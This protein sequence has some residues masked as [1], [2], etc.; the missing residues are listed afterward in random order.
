MKTINEPWAEVD[1]TVES[2]SQY[3][4]S[5]IHKYMVGTCGKL[6]HHPNYIAYHL[7]CEKTTKHCD[8]NGDPEP[9]LANRSKEEGRRKK[10]PPE[11]WNGK[12]RN[13]ILCLY[14]GYFLWVSPHTFVLHIN[15]GLLMLLLLLLLLLCSFIGNTE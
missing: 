11:K 14:H 2:V 6:E 7:N 3:R 12:K 10:Q 9:G 13:M 8:K 4:L 5:N 15:C 1:A